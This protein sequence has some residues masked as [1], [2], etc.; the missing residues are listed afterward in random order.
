MDKKEGLKKKNSRWEKDIFLSCLCCVGRDHCD[1]PITRP[2]E[3]YRVY[4]CL[5]MCDQE[6]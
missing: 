5:I 6:Q 2:E 1:G 4:V 3:S